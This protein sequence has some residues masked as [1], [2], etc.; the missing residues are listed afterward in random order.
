MNSM[1]DIYAYKMKNDI[2]V[3]VSLIRSVKLMPCFTFILTLNKMLRINT[4][5]AQIRLK[6]SKTN[7]T[8]RLHNTQQHKTINI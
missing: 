8:S 3:L 7:L 5:K 6:T 4:D 2:P 1:N